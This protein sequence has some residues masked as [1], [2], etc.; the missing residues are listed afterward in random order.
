MYNY[1]FHP[2]AKKELS[3][4]NNSVQILFTK[5]L[6]KI[7]KS[8]QLGQDL[9]YKNNI[10]LTGLKKV[11]F[12]NKRYRIVYEVCEQEVI[13]YIIAIGKRD[14]MEVYEKAGARRD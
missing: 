5:A 13:I 4:L 10:D 14:R 1:K 12:D 11:Y 3:K 9:G 2:D 7:L 6:K 8:P